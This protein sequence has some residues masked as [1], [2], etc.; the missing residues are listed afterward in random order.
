V[1]A[2]RNAKAAAPTPAPAPAPSLIRDSLSNLSSL[3]LTDLHIASNGSDDTSRPGSNKRSLTISTK[4]FAPREK[5][6]DSDSEEEDESPRPSTFSPKS[7]GRT[8]RSAHSPFFGSRGRA[9]TSPA[10][11]NLVNFMQANLHLS[12]DA[13][14]PAP[15]AQEE[16]KTRSRQ[17]S[18]RSR[19]N[20]DC[21]TADGGSVVAKSR[22]GSADYTLRCPSRAEATIHED[23][24]EDGD[25]EEAEEEELKQLEPSR[26]RST[27]LVHTS[28]TATMSSQRSV[29]ASD[30]AARDTKIIYPPRASSTS[31]V[32]TQRSG[33]TEQNLWSNNAGFRASHADAAGDGNDSDVPTICDEDDHSDGE[34][35]GPEQG[36]N[37]RSQVS[38]P[39]HTI[40]S[41][42]SF[43]ARPSFLHPPRPPSDLRDGPG[44]LHVQ[45]RDE[46]PSP[47]SMRR[48]VPEASR[49]T[50]FG[51]GHTNIVPDR[52]IRKNN[53]SLAATGKSRTVPISYTHVEASPGGPM[54]PAAG[55]GGGF[56]QPTFHTPVAIKA[57]TGL[58]EEYRWEESEPTAQHILE[59]MVSEFK[60]AAARHEEEL[61]ARPRLQRA[62]SD[63][64]AGSS[65]N[66][67]SP[68]TH[69]D[70][71]FLRMGGHTGIGAVSFGRDS[72]GSHCSGMKALVCDRPSMG[73]E[74]GEMH[75]CHGHSPADMAQQALRERQQHFSGSMFGRGTSPHAAFA[76]YSPKHSPGSQFPAGANS[77]RL[78]AFQHGLDVNSPGFREGSVENRKR[79]KKLNSEAKLRRMSMC[80]QA[81]NRS[82]SHNQPALTAIAEGNS[83]NESRSFAFSPCAK[84]KSFSALKTRAARR[85]SSAFQKHN[86][87]DVAMEPSFASHHSGVD[88]DL[89]FGNH[90]HAADSSIGHGDGHLFRSTSCLN[91]LNFKGV[92]VGGVYQHCFDNACPLVA[93]PSASDIRVVDVVIQEDNTLMLSLYL[94]K[95]KRVKTLDLGTKWLWMRC[96]P[97]GFL[98]FRSAVIPYEKNVCYFLPK[99]PDDWTSQIQNH[100]GAGVSAPLGRLSAVAGG[101]NGTMSMF[102]GRHRRSSIVPM[103][104]FNPRPRQSPTARLHKEI[105][106]DCQPLE[107]IT[108]CEGL[109]QDEDGLATE[110]AYDTFKMHSDDDLNLSVNHMEGPE[111]DGIDLT[112]LDLQETAAAQSE[113]W[114]NSHLLSLVFDF[115]IS[116]A[117]VF[118]RPAAAAAVPTKS[119]ARRSQ[120]KDAAA[121][122]EAATA[123]PQLQYCQSVNKTWALAAY[124]V[125]ARR[126]SSLVA[127]SQASFDFPRYQAFATKFQSGVYLSE[128]V[129]KNVYCVYNPASQNL[130]ALSV[131]DIDDLRERDMTLAVTQEIHISLLCSAM[132]TLRICPNLVIVNSLFQSDYNVPTPLWSDKRSF[133]DLRSAPRRAN[134]ALRKNQV[135]SGSYQYIRTEFCS[136]GD[137]EERLR[138]IGAPPDLPTVQAM[139][140]QMCFSLYACREKLCMRHFDVK[141]LN[142][143]VTSPEIL[144]AGGSGAAPAQVPA[145][146]HLQVGLGQHVFNLSMNASS[147]CLIK[148]ADFGTSA[149]GSSGLGDPITIQQVSEHSIVLCVHCISL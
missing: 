14:Q 38:S 111:A 78:S 12:E 127:A 139:L 53:R 36:A 27:K 109:E 101:L 138:R 135:E 113:H 11:V 57:V 34:L 70:S 122:A 105:E 142:F 45:L 145:V 60:V 18:V 23:A 37:Q 49:P 46:E 75:V 9:L 62:A 112:A 59:I 2:A 16:S 131:M 94:P 136:G 140:F 147:V 64:Y 68:A 97:T 1:L 29:S 106:M 87:S 43:M 114:S 8:S 141:L 80:A 96:S 61:S 124:M 73:P 56:L 35:P 52:P 119:T 123:A 121:S 42:A 89:S 81:F 88:C 133:A 63:P 72:I 82:E 47:G 20:S 7:T 107:E 54:A 6:N 125:V 67:S 44:Y 48:S 126:K 30:A 149:V 92:V 39:V 10:E 91:E 120:R 15:T 83:V 93:A 79:K 50:V 84:A 128:G 148:L 103:H 19:H 99:H 86:T 17:N 137:V 51:R 130:E 3:T 95:E 26:A 115:L 90:S 129:C 116:D 33:L 117:E 28:S 134:A 25:E 118:G 74:D 77:H 31:P 21:S 58:V 100:N 55:L 98:A 22:C 13:P 102:G 5:S 108:R 76:P 24:N 71:D 32:V 132:V 143:F 66:I 65:F 69:R 146:T 144:H 110:E 104:E 40:P 41:A 4:R 85:A